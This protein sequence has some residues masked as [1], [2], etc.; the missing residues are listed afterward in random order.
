MIQELCDSL[1]GAQGRSEFSIIVVC[2]I[3]GFSA[4]SREHESP[5]TAMFIKRFYLKLLT[6]YFP[7]AVYAKPTGDGLLLVFP[8]DEKSLDGASGAVFDACFQCLHDFPN[9]FSDDP[10]IN[11]GTPDK[12]GFGVSRGPVCCLYS[13]SEVIDYSGRFLNLASR[14]MDLARPSGIVVDAN[15]GKGL[16]P[17]GYQCHFCEAN[18]Y[19]R[20]IAETTPV[21]ILYSSPEVEIGSSALYPLTEPRASSDEHKMKVSHLMKLSGNFRLELTSEA[22]SSDGV[23]TTVR[24]ANPKMPKFYKS[25]NLAKSQYGKDSKGPHC[26]ISID[27]LKAIV[28]QE[29][30]GARKELLLITE[31]E[32]RQDRR[33]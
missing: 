8:Y 33:T 2:D 22:F 13:G 18:V 25:R 31:Y 12:L 1:I 30:I 27:E 6:S 17:E 32:P 20:G 11:F 4:F 15:Y 3:R 19:I 21:K 28:S 29:K 26:T 14:L 16:I 7:F 5:D 23:H 10:M 24:F 9:M